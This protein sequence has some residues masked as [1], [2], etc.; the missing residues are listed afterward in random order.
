MY[1][2]FTVLDGIPRED[3]HVVCKIIIVHKCMVS[4]GAVTSNARI[5][6]SISFKWSMPSL[7]IEG[8]ANYSNTVIV[9]KHH[10]KLNNIQH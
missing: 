9:S 4:G 1:K 8:P 3:D 7:G 2:I 6:I 10:Y 5:F